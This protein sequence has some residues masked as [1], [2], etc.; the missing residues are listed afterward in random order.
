MS[1]D[2][3][4]DALVV[5]ADQAAATRAALARAAAGELLTP[6]EL[7]A[8]FHLKKSAFHARAR[9]GQFDRF[10]VHPAIG[11]RHYSGALVWRYMQGDP[12]LVE[13]TFGRRR[14]A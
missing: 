5:P 8:I 1:G 11:L 4:R 7:A 6:G 13:S 12:L 2:A 14:R 10:K 3:N 9:A